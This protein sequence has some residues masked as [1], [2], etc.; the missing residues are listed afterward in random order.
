ML[1]TVNNFIDK[2]EGILTITLISVATIIT[3]L[4]VIFRY[5]F[6]NSIFWAEEVVLYAIICMSFVGASMG[7]RHGAHISVDILKS[8]IGASKTR[9]FHI[10]S[11]LLG[12]L[13]SVALAYY[14]G[15][16][17]LIT[18][19]RGQLSPALRIPVAWV[20]LPIS[21]AGVM[22]VFRYLWIIRCSWKQEDIYDQ[23]DKSNFA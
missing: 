10:V 22:L 12:I 3:F 1:R 23:E 20:Y 18:L 19:S 21:I 2:L 9:W 13:F 6:N 7:V 4:Q 8:M 17:F 16:L 14:G 15:K 5:V 11:A